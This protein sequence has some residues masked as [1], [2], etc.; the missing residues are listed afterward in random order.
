MRTEAPRAP[1]RRGKGG[2]A[3]RFNEELHGSNSMK[4]SEKK[5][6]T[7]SFLNTL[8]SPWVKFLFQH[9]WT[10]NILQIKRRDYLAFGF[11][12]RF[13]RAITLQRAI[14]WGIQ[15]SQI[16]WFSHFDSSI[17]A[18]DFAVKV[19]KKWCR[20]IIAIPRYIKFLKKCKFFPKLLKISKILTFH[21]TNRA[22]HCHA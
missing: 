14:V 17:L 12:D 1:A 10:F 13:F 8:K 11:F 15:P 2:G 5:A 19:F 7:S 3:Q 16:V 20:R 9:Y 21:R 18:P 22:H 4:I 6:N